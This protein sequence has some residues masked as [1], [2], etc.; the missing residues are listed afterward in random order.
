M[1]N[2]LPQVETVELQSQI[3]GQVSLNLFTIEP[4][5]NLRTSSQSAVFLVGTNHQVISQI[6]K[7][8]NNPTIISPKAAG[9][10]SGHV[11]ENTRINQTLEVVELIKEYFLPITNINLYDTH[12]VFD[13]PK[14][15]QAYFSL[16]QNYLRQIK[17]LDL[18]Y[19]SNNTPDD[20]TIIDLRPERPVLT[21]PLDPT[22]DPIGTASATP[23][24]KPSN[25][26][27]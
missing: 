7:P 12:V 23:N 16:D 17:A 21:T 10:S 6:D 19:N 11:I 27:N 13:L 22:P 24:P 15:R 18:I 25:Q 4:L 2:A 8:T 9:L 26:S 20:V 5:A 14:K 1:G 3:P